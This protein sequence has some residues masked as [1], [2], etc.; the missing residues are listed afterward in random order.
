MVVAH[1]VDVSFVVGLGSLIL[2]PPLT[3]PAPRALDFG[4]VLTFRECLSLFFLSATVVSGL[5]DDR[6]DAATRSVRTLAGG[7]GHRHDAGHALIVSGSQRSTSRSAK[8]A[9]SGLGLVVLWSFSAE[10]LIAPPFTGEALVFFP[11]WV[12]PAA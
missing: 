12:P 10:L 5:S 1:T 4:R 7:T 11:T 3:D 9:G 6:G 2:I 8:S